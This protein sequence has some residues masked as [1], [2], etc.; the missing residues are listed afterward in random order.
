MDVINKDHIHFN[1]F[2]L[3][4]HLRVYVQQVKLVS[5]CIYCMNHNTC[6]VSLVIICTFNVTKIYSEPDTWT[7]LMCN[8]W[9]L[10]FNF[11][12]MLY[13]IRYSMSLTIWNDVML[14]L[15]I[16]YLYLIFYPKKINWWFGHY[17][18]LTT[19]LGEKFTSIIKYIVALCE[20]K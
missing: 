17:K 9:G 4:R 11:L 6:F 1:T 20:S 8:K 7:L 2:G 13:K 5:T 3:L 19:L 14:Y 12:I 16:V 15:F 18:T 10:H